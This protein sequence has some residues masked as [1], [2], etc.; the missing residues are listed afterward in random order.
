M[1]SIAAIAIAALLSSCAT[2]APPAAPGTVDHIVLIWLKRP[3]N[4]QDRQAVRKAA[5]D[6]RSIPGIR[7]LDHGTPLASDRPVV[8][9]SFDVGL[10]MRFTSAEALQSYEDHPV[11]VQKVKEVLLPLSKKVQVYDVVR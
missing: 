7:F 3:G 10:V 2:I 1:K 6:L 8:D 11:H 4:E 5:D 9:D